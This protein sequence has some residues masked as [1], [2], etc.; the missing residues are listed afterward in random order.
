MATQQQQT[1]VPQFSQHR[2]LSNPE[3]A[4]YAKNCNILANQTRD[5]RAREILNNEVDRVIEALVEGI[6]EENGRASRG[7]ERRGEGREGR[8]G[9]RY[10]SNG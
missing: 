4:Q 10:M 9:S 2:G 7:F 3:L 1:R 8:E 6:E 5:S